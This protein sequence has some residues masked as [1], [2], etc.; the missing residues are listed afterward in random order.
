[1]QVRTFTG[2][3]TPKQANH[4]MFQGKITIKPMSAPGGEN[5]ASSIRTGALIG[6]QSSFAAF[7]AEETVTAANA[8][9]TGQNGPGSVTAPSPANIPQGTVHVLRKGENIWQLARERYRVDPAEILRHNNITHPERL[10]V[11]QKIRIPD[12]ANTAIQ[13]GEEVVASWYGRYHHGRRMANGERFDMHNPTIAHRDMPFGTR[14]E[15]ENPTTGEKVEAVVTDR[16]PYHPGRDVD[17]SYG[18]AEQLSLT[19]QGVGSLKLRIL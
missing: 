12:G 7:L 13:G 6:V 8:K 2:T 1:M 17:I 3:D 18:L 4:S 14:V 16:G 19:R 9:A 11:G 5:R 10:R 15:L